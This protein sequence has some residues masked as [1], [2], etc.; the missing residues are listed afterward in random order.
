MSLDILTGHR[1]RTLLSISGIVIGTAAVIMLAA[2]GLGAEQAVVG[3]IEAMGANLIIVTAGRTRISGGRV[4]R[5]SLAKTLKSTDVQAI[6]S[7]CPS[8]EMAAGSITRSILIHY[9]GQRVKTSLI[10][11]EPD[12]FVIR[13]LLTAE[14]HTYSDFDERTRRRVVV[15]A[16]TAAHNTFTG[17][18]P[19]GQ[20]V[21]LNRQP[22]RVI[23]FTQPKGADLSGRDQ[24]DKIFVPLSTALRRLVNVDYLDHIFV[25]AQDGVSFERAEEEIRSVLRRRHK[26]NHKSDDFS[27][28]NQLDLIRLQERTGRS[29]RVLARSVAVLCWIIGGIGILAVM[30]LSVRE[31]R[32]EIGLRRAIGATKKDICTQFLFEA[33]LMAALGGGIG[34]ILGLVG[35][36]LPDVLGWWRASIS[37][38]AVWAAFVISVFLGLV[39]GLYPAIR[40]AWLTPIGA[41]RSS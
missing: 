30:L 20:P 29:L 24:D 13:K 22:F 37:W 21:R 32:S 25:R 4:V 23:G 3:R 2:A 7:E 1:L 6:R 36:W 33:G 39:C 12:G 11:M 15:F 38:P 8:V 31:R 34:T 18:R 41:L 16:P 27:I 26:T 40:A 28:Y 19:L 9:Q 17:D 5:S 35:S 14:G 10:G